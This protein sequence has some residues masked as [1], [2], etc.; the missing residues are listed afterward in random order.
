M[1]KHLHSPFLGCRYLCHSYVS[2]HGVQKKSC[3]FYSA[4]NNWLFVVLSVSADPVAVFYS[5]KIKVQFAHQN[6]IQAFVYY[7]LNLSSA[8]HLLHTALKNTKP[9]QCSKTL[10][11]WVIFISWP[12]LLLASSWNSSI[13][14]ITVIFLLKGDLICTIFLFVFKRKKNLIC[15]CDVCV[16]NSILMINLMK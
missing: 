5:L 1:I 14:M 12:I 2:F 10:F 9:K 13:T 3:E 6:Q 16:K 15:L 11:Q 8:L 4:L 7:S